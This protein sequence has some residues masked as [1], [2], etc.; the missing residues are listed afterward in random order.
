MPTLKINKACFGWPLP[1][2]TFWGICSDPSHGALLL[3]SP[4][5]RNTPRARLAESSSN[6][7]FLPFLSQMLQRS[8]QLMIIHSELQWVTLAF[9]LLK[10]L[11]RV[12]VISHKLQVCSIWWSQIFE[13]ERIWKAVGSMC[14]FK[15]HHKGKHRTTISENGRFWWREKE[16]SY[17]DIGMEN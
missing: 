11:F 8:Y 14:N 3:R 16:K 2:M 6:H 9:T 7:P 13:E 15:S 5:L 17:Y 4:L 12:F 1:L 10:H